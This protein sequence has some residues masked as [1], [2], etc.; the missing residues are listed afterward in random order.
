MG[1]G[2][3]TQSLPSSMPDPTVAR[4]GRSVDRVIAISMGDG[5]GIQCLPS[6]MPN[7]IERS[8]IN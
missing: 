3:G 4:I 6:S 8:L 5:D 2:D 1:D 7:P